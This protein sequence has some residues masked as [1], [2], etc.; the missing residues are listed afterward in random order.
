MNILN[1]RKFACFDYDS[2]ESSQVKLGDV[3]FKQ[4]THKGEDLFEIGVIIQI[5][6]EREFRTDMFGNCCMSE[7]TLATR[8]QVLMY[9]PDIIKD[10]DETQI[11]ERTFFILTER[12]RVKNRISFYIGEIVNGKMKLIDN[13]FTVSARSNRGLENEAVNRLIELG[14][15]YPKHVD[16]NG[17]I[18]HRTKD[19]NI[20]HVE[21]T[22]VAYINFK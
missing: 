19:F 21:S 6:D 13:D 20:I 8:E 5:H 14:T 4:Q 17:Y 10:I 11:V 15:L 22:N 7:I 1:Y 3:V 12:K 16:S 2:V 18:N 9:R